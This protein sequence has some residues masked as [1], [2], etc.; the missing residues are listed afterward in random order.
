MAWQKAAADRQPVQVDADLTASRRTDPE[1]PKSF[2]ITSTSSVVISDSGVDRIRTFGVGAI[3]VKNSA[4]RTEN[5]DD[6]GVGGARWS[7]V[8]LP[9]TGSCAGLSTPSS[10]PA[11]PLCYLDSGRAVGPAWDCSVEY[12]SP[13][14]RLVAVVDAS[15]TTSTPTCG[16]QN[17]R[18]T[19][20]PNLRRHPLT[21]DPT[22]EVEYISGFEIA[23]S[24]TRTRRD[25]SL[26]GGPEG[27][28]GIATFA[29]RSERLAVTHKDPFVLKLPN[30]GGWLM[31]LA[32]T[33]ALE[34]AADAPCSGAVAS[35]PTDSL[36]D[37]VAWWSRDPSFDDGVATVRGPYFMVDSL[38]ALPGLELRF[39]LGVPTAAIVEHEG[40]DEPPMDAPPEDEEEEEHPVPWLD[41]GDVGGAL[42]PSDGPF[43][44]GLS[45]QDW[46]LAVAGY[47]HTPFAT[48]VYRRGLAL[49]RIP[50]GE[51]L[52]F[53]AFGST[54][55][56]NWTAANVAPGELAGQIRVWGCDTQRV[57]PMPQVVPFEV[58][59]GEKMANGPV[60]A[61]P[62]VVATPTGLNLYFSTL[63]PRVGSGLVIDAPHGYGIW[64]AVA[65]PEAAAVLE[66]RHSSGPSYRDAV[67]GIDFVLCLRPEGMGAAGPRD[68]VAPHGSSGAFLIDPDVVQDPDTGDW[69]VY[70]GQDGAPLALYIGASADGLTTWLDAWCGDVIEGGGEEDDAMEAVY[71]QLPWLRVLPGE[72]DAGGEQDEMEAVYRQLPWLRVPVEGTAGAGRLAPEESGACCEGTAEPTGG[73]GANAAAPES[74]AQPLAPGGCGCG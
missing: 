69:R 58:A 37:I 45:Y 7:G 56:P 17:V 51:L 44:L 74:S 30:G 70:V 39:W 22:W 13:D 23:G 67:F 32:R 42:R 29:T 26:Y 4:A 3:E 28:T 36:G 24:S 72:P 14:P 33:R 65:V 49:K 73:E 9:T 6:P 2:V 62:C 52:A 50:L 46:A 43:D 71:R 35:K 20:I 27:L 21:T 5:Y 61:D 25:D 34:G 38:R 48:R 16:D 57:G 18:A 40:S 59:F 60:L 15:L 31:L 47:A 63:E 12:T 11:V 68:Q 55:E 41:V 64:R 66:Y 1:L 54:D 53:L 8:P 19:C 10:C